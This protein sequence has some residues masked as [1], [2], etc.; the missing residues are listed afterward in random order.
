MSIPTLKNDVGKIG[1]FFSDFIRVIKQR[2]C[3]K[4]SKKCETDVKVNEQI[5]KFGITH[6]RWQRNTDISAFLIII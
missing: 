5:F 1:K 2:F 4:I 6:R 3:K